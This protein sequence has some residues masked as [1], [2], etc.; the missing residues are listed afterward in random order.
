MARCEAR[1]RGRM[2][3]TGLKVCRSGNY[4]VKFEA[5]GF[6][7]VEIPSAKV[8][9]TET[10]VLDE[11]LE[12]GEQINGKPTP[13]PPGQFAKRSFQQ[14]ESAFA[15]GSRHFS[16]TNSRK[17]PGPGDARQTNTHA[18]DPSTAGPD[19]DLAPLVATFIESAN[20]GG[21]STSNTDRTV[22]MV[23]GA[24]S[25]D[26]YF[27]TA[28]YAI[29]APRI[30]GTETRGPIRLH[31]ALAWIHGPGMILTPILGAHRLQ[32]KKQRG[33]STWDRPAHGP[34]AIVTGGAFGL[35]VPSVSL[36]F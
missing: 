22:H 30:P 31:K 14:Y 2:A 23:L 16:G 1:P 27:M 15:R 25:G 10:T 34:V 33:K 29:R 13:A 9:G 18:E 5:A 21:K 8:N 24:V 7:T 6:K 4:R 19:N 35:A 12:A 32:S 17:R 20:A 26:L 11:K 28:Y 3:P 36:K